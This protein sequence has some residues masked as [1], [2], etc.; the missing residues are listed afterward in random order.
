MTP[1]TCFWSMG[2]P[3]RDPVILL[4]AWWVSLALSCSLNLHHSQCGFLYNHPYCPPMTPL[5]VCVFLAVMAGDCGDEMSSKSQTAT[6]RRHN[7]HDFQDSSQS[8]LFSCN[9]AFET[10]TPV[11]LYCSFHTFSVIFKNFLNVRSPKYQLL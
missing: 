2:V 1:K 9:F 5:R 7:M 8:S 4:W 11:C 3:G 6:S 10:F